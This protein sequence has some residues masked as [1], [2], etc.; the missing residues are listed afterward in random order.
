MKRKDCLNAFMEEEAEI[1]GTLIKI[2]RES[3]LLNDYTKFSTVALRHVGDI[4]DIDYIV[5]D[6][7]TPWNELKPYSLTGIKICKPAKR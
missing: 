4:E 6:A 2:A 1:A 7:N 5:T 3:I